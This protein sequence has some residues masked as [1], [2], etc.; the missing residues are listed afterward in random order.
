MKRLLSTLFVFFFF[1][2]SLS[3]QSLTD[4]ENQKQKTQ[5]ELAYAN[6]LLD[7][8][9]KNRINSVNQLN[10]LKKQLLL[11]NQLVGQ[12]Q[13]QIDLL[14]QEISEKQL[15]ISD[16]NTD[17][18]NLKEEYAKLIVYAK[19][20]SSQLDLLV[21]IFSA[22]DFNQ[23]YLRIRFYK[24]FMEYRAG[25]AK[26][27][28]E[29]QNSIIKELASI[30][31]AANLLKETKQVKTRELNSLHSNERSY[32]TNINKLRRQEN[33]LRKDIEK[34]KAS[35]A[36]LDKAIA[37]LIAEEARKAATV[38]RDA[39]YLNLSAGFQGNKG[40]LPWPT[41]KGVITGL[42][43]EHNHPVLKGVKIKNNGV[44]ITTDKDSYVR[45]IFEGEV[46]KI[47]SIPGSNM[48]VLVRHGDFLTVYSNITKISVKVGDTVKALQSL[49]QVFTDPTTQKGIYNL[50]IW[51]ENTIQNPTNWILP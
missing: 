18:E 50:Q 9:Q 32:Q 45:A 33:Q 40:R 29:V 19:R 26:Q 14:E 4:L 25:Q 48:A 38:I 39:R 7:K 12:T 44:D 27:I 13:N 17:L 31:Q 10:I 30:E 35:M 5:K 21:F 22:Q 28:Q 46:K 41:A 3:S 2:F 47:V 23:A 15:L 36:A 51:Q 6:E 24:Q 1:L 8:T 37:D 42:F 20:N 43:G 49:G 16:L 11:Q 34:R